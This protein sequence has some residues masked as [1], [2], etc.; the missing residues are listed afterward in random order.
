MTDHGFYGAQEK[1]ETEGLSV[2]AAADK[3]WSVP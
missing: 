1:R 3:P 2:P